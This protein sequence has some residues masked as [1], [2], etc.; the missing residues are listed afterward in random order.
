MANTGGSEGSYYPGEGPEIPAAGGDYGAPSPRAAK[1][2][3][4]PFQA[5]S[6][7][8]TTNPAPK[9]LMARG[10]SRD[11]PRNPTEPGES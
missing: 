10:T 1:I 6:S 2:G 11:N 5:P 8:P 3:Q 4:A 9:L 7:L